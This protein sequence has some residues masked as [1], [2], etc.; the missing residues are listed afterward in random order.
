MFGAEALVN[1][2]SQSTFFELPRF[3]KF[4]PIETAVVTRPPGVRENP[5]LHQGSSPHRAVVYQN[6]HGK[7][8]NVMG[9]VGLDQLDSR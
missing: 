5:L 8:T 6:W 7:W 1:G 3:W 2:E 4:A 9:K